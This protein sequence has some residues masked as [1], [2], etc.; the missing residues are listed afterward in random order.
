[1]KRFTLYAAKLIAICCW[2]MAAGIPRQ[3]YAESGET[4]A[5]MPL[6]G[7]NFKGKIIVE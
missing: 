2:F 7:Q 4:P 1:M 6:Q 3:A 5:D